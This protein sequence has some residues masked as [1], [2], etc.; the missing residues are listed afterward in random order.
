MKR[1][2]SKS[3]LDIMNEDLS[4]SDLAEEREMLNYNEELTNS[5]D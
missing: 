1:L 5:S 2:I 3:A 4:S